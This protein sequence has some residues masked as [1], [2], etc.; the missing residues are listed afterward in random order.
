VPILSKDKD[1]IDKVQQ[2]F[3]LMPDEM[4][5][6]EVAST[7]LMIVDGYLGNDKASSVS[8]LLSVFVTYAS[9]KGLDDSKI[10][11]MLRLAAASVDAGD[12]T[13]VMH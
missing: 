1:V 13:P 12:H 5:I 10:S 8:L 4:T 11:L 3:D 9:G 6:D 7:V 2:A